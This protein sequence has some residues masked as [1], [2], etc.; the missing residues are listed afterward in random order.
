[1]DSIFV[2]AIRSAS[3]TAFLIERVVSSISETIPRL[4]ACG[5]RLANAQ[6]LDRGLPVRFADRLGDHDSCFCRPDVQP[7]DDAFLNH[8]SLAIT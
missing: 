7:G 3:S 8:C 5:A 4:R 2:P 6:N 1:M